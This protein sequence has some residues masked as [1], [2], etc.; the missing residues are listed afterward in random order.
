M[1]ILF[2][3]PTGALDP[4]MVGE[5]LSVIRELAKEGTNSPRRVRTRQGGY[6]LAKEGLTLV[7][8][9]HAMRFA[10]D[11]ADTIV[12]MEGGRIREV[13]PPQA[14]FADPQ[15]ERAGRFLTRP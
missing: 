11:V 13:A 10:R 8:V 4:E 12:F 1:D 2:D 7:V 6:E 3:E 14:F 5:V 15:S 9:T